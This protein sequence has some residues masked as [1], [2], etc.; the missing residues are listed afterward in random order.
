ML[1]PSMFPDRMF[2]TPVSL[3]N[4]AL[5]GCNGALRFN[6][7]HHVLCIQTI[8]SAQWKLTIN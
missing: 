2:V 8:C 5:S 7:H 4:E 6:F 3:G 1:N